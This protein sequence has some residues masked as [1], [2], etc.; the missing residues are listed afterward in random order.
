M[1]CHSD[2]E[3]RTVRVSAVQ[4]PPASGET[5][6]N[7][8]TIRRLVE[9]TR[10]HRPDFILLS[11]LATT[12]YF[13]GHH[14]PST[15]LAEP[16]PGPQHGSRGS[17]GEIPRDH[18]PPSHVREVG[19]SLLQQCRPPFPRGRDRGG[20]PDQR[21]NG[22][23]LPEDPPR[24]RGSGGLQESFYFTAGTAYRCFIPRRRRSAC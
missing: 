18:H 16:I 1:A 11:E 4:L 3:G 17:T 22:L 14:N 19:R 13:G 8:K 6:D 20:N 12:P 2:G 7:L 24:G 21:R 9:R 15:E 10:E 5:E 23:L